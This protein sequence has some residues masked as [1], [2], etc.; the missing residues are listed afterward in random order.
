MELN[1]TIY[2]DRPGG[3][4]WGAFVFGWVWGVINH[5]PIMLVSFVPFAMAVLTTTARN[6]LTL[7]T[8]NTAFTEVL[9]INLVFHIWFGLAGNRWSWQS[10]RWGSLDVYHAA[11]KKWQIV[12]IIVFL[13]EV[14][15]FLFV[16][17]SAL[18]SRAIHS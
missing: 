1:T 9:L 17:Y 10:G 8:F 15:A 3:W 13:L 16:A 6:L 2:E 14:T 4:S 11:Q 5:A 18:F 12:A 7:S